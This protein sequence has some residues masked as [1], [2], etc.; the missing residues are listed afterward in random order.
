MLF[1]PK[2]KKLNSKVRFQHQTFTQKVRAAQQYKRQA[3]RVPETEGQK[4]LA[5]IGLDSLWSR[6]AV[7]VG[8]LG[9][10]YLVYIPSFLSVKTITVNGSD[11]QLAQELVK[12][13]REYIADSPAY[14]A[15]HNVVFFKKS[16]V[17]FVVNQFPKFFT[18]STPG[19]SKHKNNILFGGLRFW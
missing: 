17:F 6:I 18:R 10:V 9:L 19:R 7:G 2:Q 4:F 5:G 16:F 15:Q 8:V 14:A 1:K 3:Q 12:T 11:D 13:V